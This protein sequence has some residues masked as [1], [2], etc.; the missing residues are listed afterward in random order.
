MAAIDLG[1]PRLALQSLASNC[2]DHAY[3]QSS[4]VRLSLHRS[5]MLF[6]VSSFLSIFIEH[7]SGFFQ[8]QLVFNFAQHFFAGGCLAAQLVQCVALEADDGFRQLLKLGQG[9][10]SRWLAWLP[11]ARFCRRCGR[12]S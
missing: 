11:A 9:L 10:L 1:P 8:V 3:A 6:F 4:P 5:A 2:K 12:H 7:Q